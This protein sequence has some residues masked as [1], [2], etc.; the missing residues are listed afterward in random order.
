[1][2]ARP[3]TPTKPSVASR[4]RPIPRV[5]TPKIRTVKISVLI[6][7]MVTVILEEVPSEGGWR[8]IQVL[9]VDS[10][11]ISVRTFEEA[12]FDDDV[13]ELHRLAEA[14]DS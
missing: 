11:D 12:L 4:H 2:S 3:K 13:E 10:P 6:P 5:V 1:M 7:T 14:A 9:S 8:T